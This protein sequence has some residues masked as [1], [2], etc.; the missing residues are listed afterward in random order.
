MDKKLLGRRINLA[1]KDKG[2]TSE[3][4][5]EACNINAT[6][7]RQIEAGSRSPS[8][9]MFISICEHLSVSPSYVLRLGIKT[10]PVSGCCFWTKSWFGLIHLVHSHKI[11]ILQKN[12]KMLS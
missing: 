7:L 8:L 12:C 6:Y 10:A 3:K 4:L 11:A 9:P 1:R 5:S 2:L